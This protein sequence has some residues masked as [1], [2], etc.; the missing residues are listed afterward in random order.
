MTASASAETGQAASSCRAA[1]KA[2]D[3]IVAARPEVTHDRLAAAVRLIVS[4]RNAL[5]NERRSGR[6]DSGRQ[7]LLDRVNAILSLA[8]SA[9]FPLAGVRWERIVAIRQAMH[10][11]AP[12]CGSDGDP[13]AA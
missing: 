7:E 10:D 2:F 12:R 13:S 1:C 11:L 8:T 3:A 6:F 9:E 5:V 4:M